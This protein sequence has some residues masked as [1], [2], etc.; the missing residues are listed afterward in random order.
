MSDPL[1]PIATREAMEAALAI[2]AFVGGEIR[3][4]DRITTDGHKAYALNPHQIIGSIAQNS[5]A[6]QAIPVVLPG[7]TA[8]PVPMPPIV[9]APLPP[10][11]P[12]PVPV[13][14]PPLPE[15]IPTKTKKSKK[16]IDFDQEVYKLLK[17]INKNLSGINTSLKELA[18]ANNSRSK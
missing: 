8:P 12:E 3:E 9:E 17:S 18:N 7:Q 5:I 4:T 2:A 11:L 16:D 14:P 10:P 1:Q 15:P 13:V 6:P